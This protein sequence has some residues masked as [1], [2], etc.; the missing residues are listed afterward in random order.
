MG[1]V[2]NSVF[3]KFDSRYEDYFQSY[4]S[5]FGR[6]LRLLKYM[7]GITNY[8]KLFADE[9][10]ELLIEAVFFQYQFQMYIYYKYAPGGKNVFNLM[11]MVVSIG[12]HLKLLGDGL[13]TL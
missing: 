12:I 2:N 5:Y 4:S 3:V 7:Y 10:I 9:L 8:G 11:L 13:C 6:A 1:K